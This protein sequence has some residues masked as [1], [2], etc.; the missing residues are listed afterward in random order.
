MRVHII[1]ENQPVLSNEST[2][3]TSHHQ[4]PIISQMR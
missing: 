3:L 2:R 1:L 4:P